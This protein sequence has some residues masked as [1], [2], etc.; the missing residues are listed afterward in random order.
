MKKLFLK[1][2]FVADVLAILFLVVCSLFFRR[3][4]SVTGVV[5]DGFGRMLTE[6]PAFLQ[7]QGLM[8]NWAG[9]GWSLVDSV[10]AL[11]L[12]FIAAVLREAIWGKNKK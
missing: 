11:I 1:I 5:T 6:A 4:D 7:S 10:C 2:L 8:E 3:Y 9:F 12:I